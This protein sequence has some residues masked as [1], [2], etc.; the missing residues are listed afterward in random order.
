MCGI[1]AVYM[2]YFYLI[3]VNVALM[4]ES[5]S[6][7][8]FFGVGLTAVLITLFLVFINENEPL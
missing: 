2:P 7:I 6:S 8:I 5:L 4:Q 3:G 1:Y